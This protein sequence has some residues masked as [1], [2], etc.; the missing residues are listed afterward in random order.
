M[1]SAASASTMLEV[2]NGK[3]IKRNAK[4]E[5]TGSFITGILTHAVQAIA[6]AVLQEPNGKNWH[7]HF[8]IPLI[9]HYGSS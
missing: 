2:T 7:L 6:K 4:L 5:R 3:I 8:C 1:I 9:V